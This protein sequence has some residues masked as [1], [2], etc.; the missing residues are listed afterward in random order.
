MSI[1]SVKTDASGNRIDTLQ[2]VLTYICRSEVSSI[3]TIYGANVSAMF[4][5][6]EMEALKAAYGATDRK[7]YYH[8]I[9]NPEDTEEIDDETLYCAGREMAEFIGCAGRE[10]A[11]FIGHFGGHYQVVMSVHHEEEGTSHIHLVASNTNIDNGR[12]MN[13]DKRRLYQMK[14]GISSIAESYGIS[15]VRQYHG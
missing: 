9:F 8:Y 15:P 5:F 10:M 1:F 7:A 12:R 6:Y 11:E 4:P 14:Q 3:D 2:N 13:L